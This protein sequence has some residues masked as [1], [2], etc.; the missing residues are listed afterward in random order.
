MKLL[1]LKRSQ[2]TRYSHIELGIEF[3]GPVGTIRP[4]GNIGITCDVPRTVGPNV[5]VAIYP[6]M[7]ATNELPATLGSSPKSGWPKPCSRPLE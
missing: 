6:A 2:L 1:Y 7:L 3:C 4:A 5:A